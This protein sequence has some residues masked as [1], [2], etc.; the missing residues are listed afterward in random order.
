MQPVA[1]AAAS[2]AAISAFAVERAIYDDSSI[3]CPPIVAIWRRFDEAGSREAIAPRT[4]RCGHRRA[5][6]PVR[7]WPPADAHTTPRRSVLGAGTERHCAVGTAPEG[8]AFCRSSLLEQNI[9][10]SLQVDRRSNDQVQSERAT[11]PGRRSRLTDV[12]R[13]GHVRELKVMELLPLA[14]SVQRNL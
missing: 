1:R 11:P 6:G 9:H 10:G 2:W 13:R 5:S 7:G 14:P 12:L 8:A 4:P 3:H